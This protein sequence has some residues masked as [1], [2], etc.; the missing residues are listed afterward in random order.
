MSEDA[1]NI[2]VYSDDAATRQR[3]I[4]GVG[5]RP[6]KDLPTVKWHEAATPWGAVDG[7]KQHSP[8]LLILDGE[9]QKSGGMSV[10]REIRDRFD[11]VPPIVI[12]TARPQDAWLAEWAGAAEVVTAPLDPLDLQQRVST[13]LRSAR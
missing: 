9:T 3:V 2:L 7:L 1:I 10:A 4:E 6:A 8:A 11:D 13:A 12:L 5:L